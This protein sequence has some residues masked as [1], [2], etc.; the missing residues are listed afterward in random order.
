MAKRLI[1]SHSLKLINIVSMLSFKLFHNGKTKA[2][3]LYTYILNKKYQI[4][5]TDKDRTVFLRERDI[6][7]LIVLFRN[8]SKRNL[9]TFYFTLFIVYILLYLDICLM[10]QAGVLI[11]F[12]IYDIQ[13]FLSIFSIVKYFIFCFKSLNDILKVNLSMLFLVVYALSHKLLTITA[14]YGS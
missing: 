1:E 10:Y 13:I 12:G 11:R 5:S 8:L 7:T 9:Q 6:L 4:I 14:I 2:A 3:D